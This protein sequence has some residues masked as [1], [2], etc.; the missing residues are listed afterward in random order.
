MS[1]KD[2]VEKYRNDIEERI[3]VFGYSDEEV[4]G[5]LL[6]KVNPGDPGG[7]PAAPGAESVF[8]AQLLGNEAGLPAFRPG[9]A[10][11]DVENGVISE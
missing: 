6:L 8:I 10:L 9:L 3:G 11:I 5:Q 7:G 1:V 4:A 2:L